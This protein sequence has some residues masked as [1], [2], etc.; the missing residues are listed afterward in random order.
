MIYC[1]DIDGTVCT[2]TSD[3][4]SAIP[5]VPIIEEINR[6]YD[7]GHTIIMMTARGS[8]S[9]IDHSELTK[10]QLQS[11]GLKHHELIMNRKPHADLFVDDRAINAYDWAMSLPT[12]R[13]IV[14]GAFDIIHP[15]YVRM[16]A[17][18]KTLCNHLT[19]A[20]H[21][22]PSY[23]GKPRPILSLHEREEILR[24]MRDVDEVVTY[25]SEDDLYQL[26]DIGGFDIR[27]LGDDYLDKHI[28]GE[29]LVKIHWIERSHGYSATRMKEAIANSLEQIR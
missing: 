5:L 21:D 27:F 7:S 11:W 20:L 2:Q 13:G 6:L 23:R 17:Q 8:V 29:E 22:D 1:F 10:Q 18:A 9:G 19:V 14:A 4:I 28:T 16:F 3:Y 12:K 26:L 15:G 25:S 24:A